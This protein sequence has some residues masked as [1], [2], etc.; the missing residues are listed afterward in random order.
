MTKPTQID[1]LLEVGKKANQDTWHVV[2]LP[3][4]NHTPYIN[5]KSE[6]PHIGRAIVD[7]IDVDCIEGETD[8]EIDRQEAE[9]AAEDEAN[10]RFIAAAANA[11]EAIS[12]LKAERDR[13]ALEN[14]QR[15]CQPIID[16]YPNADISHVDFR[17]RVTEWAEDLLRDDIT[18]ALGGN[19]E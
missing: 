13:E 1:E 15:M 5:T 6:D 10:M 3:W 12:E 8:E 19:D 18:K 16:G 9:I 7:V 14:A 17:I 11:R 4:N 2:G